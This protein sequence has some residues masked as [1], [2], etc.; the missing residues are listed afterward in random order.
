MRRPAGLSWLPDWVW[1]AYLEYLADEGPTGF[2]SYAECTGPDAEVRAFFERII[3]NVESKPAWRSLAKRKDSLDDLVTHSNINHVAIVLEMCH[4]SYFS[5]D[6]NSTVAES[7]RTRQG[8]YVRNLAGKLDLEINKLL[9][10]S[11][12]LPEEF[13]GVDLSAIQQHLRALR[14]SADQWAESKPAADSS[15]KGIPHRRHFIIEVGTYLEHF[16]GERLIRCVAALTSCLFEPVSHTT[17][18]ATLRARSDAQNGV[19][20]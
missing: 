14:S 18:G 15:G 5:Y 2:R 3:F 4:T 8:A 11:Q 16:Y 10:R 12:Q 17:V 7:S 20:S 9:S 1:G 6:P 13:L 19:V